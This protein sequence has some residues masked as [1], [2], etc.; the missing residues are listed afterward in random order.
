MTVL[1][2]RKTLVLLGA[3]GLLAAA[4]A[5]P[6]IAYAAD[7][8]PAPS[9]STEDNR[10]TRPGRPGPHGGPRMEK[11]TAALAQA[12]G[13]T[14]DKLREALTALRVERVDK[15]EFAAALAAKLGVPEEKVTAA[16]ESA[17]AKADEARRADRTAKLKERLDKAVAD[18]KLTRA[19][20][21]AVRKAADAG[22]LWGEP[23]R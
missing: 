21:D 11:D 15:G 4:V 8:S 22:V 5:G 19:E 9:Q 20:A 10:G 2:K 12:L 18:G 7:P 13:V 23:T 16:L 6:A 1:T 14:E 3:G 17:R